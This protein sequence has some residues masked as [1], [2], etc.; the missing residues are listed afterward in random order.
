[1]I[2][3]SRYNPKKPI[4]KNSFYIQSHG[5]NAGRPLRNPIPNSWEVTTNITYAYEICYILFHSQELKVNI[6][7]SVIPYLRLSDYKKL[8]LPL[9]QK[10]NSNQD[11]IIEKYKALQAIEKMQETIK[12]KQ[13][14]FSK[15][16]VSLC[17]AVLAEI[18]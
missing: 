17:R 3:I 18:Y 11:L 15:M 4:N 12:Q 1:M 5:Y 10:N 2:Y 9:L 14:L 7:G 6:I 16:Q 8:L 13:L